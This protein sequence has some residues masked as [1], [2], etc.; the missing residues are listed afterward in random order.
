M[1]S[2][3]FGPQNEE[4]LPSWS[5]LREGAVEQLSSG[6]GDHRDGAGSYKHAYE[7]GFT[8]ER[9]AAVT[10]AVHMGDDVDFQYAMASST[11]PEYIGAVNT[12]HALHLMEEGG[13]SFPAPVEVSERLHTAGV[14]VEYAAALIR[15]GLYESDIQEYHANGV[16][17]EYAIASSLSE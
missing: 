4:D 11:P 6:G 13:P 7:H 8:P 12:A 2:D 5:L 9:V 3:N 10:L 15:A 14:P 1:W 17:I 16:A